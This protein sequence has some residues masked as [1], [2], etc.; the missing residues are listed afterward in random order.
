MNESLYV[1]LEIKSFAQRKQ[2][3]DM[4]VS[5]KIKQ[6]S[7]KLDILRTLINLFYYEQTCLHER[8]IISSFIQIHLH[9]TI[10]G[11]LPIL[12]ENFPYSLEQ[13]SNTCS[14]SPRS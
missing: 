12:I 7:I 1:I 10:N 5:I 6:S 8:L 14:S 13:N 4:Q 9:R 3:F 11:K 2:H